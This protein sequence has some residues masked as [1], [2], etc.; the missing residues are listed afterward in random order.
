MGLR[1]EELDTLTRAFMLDELKRDRT[2]GSLHLSAR[3]TVAGIRVWPALLKWALRDADPARLAEQLR[4]D[5]RMERVGTLGTPGG[6]DAARVLA[7]GEFNRFYCRGVCRRAMARGHRVVEVVRAHD[8]DQPRAGAQHLVGKRL[9]AEYLLL[10]LRRPPVQSVAGVPGGPNS[11]LSVR[12]ARCA[13]RRGGPQDR[14]R[15][16]G[17]G[18]LP[19]RSRRR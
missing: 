11:G 13:E 18:P 15:L 10:D 5:G 19:T 16:T 9:G 3:L 6:R 1:F 8:P 17:A 7:E 4:T 2:Q 14:R 12:L